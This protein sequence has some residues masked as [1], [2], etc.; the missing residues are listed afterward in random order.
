MEGERGLQDAKPLQIHLPCSGT[1]CSASE[2]SSVGVGS[3]CLD[4]PPFLPLT[5]TTHTWAVPRRC[6]GWR[7][8]VLLKQEAA[9][10]GCAPHGVRQAG[11]R[12]GEEAAGWGSLW[13]APV[14]VSCSQP[15]EP[16]PSPGV[17]LLPICTLIHHQALPSPKQSLVAAKSCGCL[18]LQS[19][20]EP[21]EHCWPH[22]GGDGGSGGGAIFCFPHYNCRL[23]QG[24]RAGEPW[25]LLPCFL[26]CSASP[27]CSRSPF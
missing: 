14:P 6:A 21:P 8:G 10:S 7:G 27:R 26:C 18:S 24:G 13:P 3:L 22:R 25:A 23:G 20:S 9:G 12:L 2:I 17:L 19:P 1:I 5:H 4:F 16:L 11:G 15:W